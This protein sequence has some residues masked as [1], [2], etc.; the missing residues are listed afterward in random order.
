MKK[1]VKTTFTIVINLG[2]KSHEICALDASA[3]VVFRENILNNS[4]ALCVLRYLHRGALM[5]IELG[6]VVP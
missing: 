2:D 5:I 4:D 3:K 1:N 6:P